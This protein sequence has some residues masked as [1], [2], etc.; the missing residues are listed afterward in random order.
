MNQ[1]IVVFKPVAAALAD[2]SARYK[3]VVFDVTTT[4]GMADAKASYKAI[5]THSITLE[6]ARVKEKADSL[7][8]GRFV[9][10][11]AKRIADA[12]DALR[13]PIKAQIEIETKRAEREREAAV[14]AEK[15]R[16]AAEEKAR[17]DAE[18][19]K[20]AADRA[21]IARQRAELEA[22]AKAE[23]DRLEEAR[24]QQEGIERAARAK[25]EEA[26]RASRAAIEA[27]EREARM[28]RE[29][30]DREAKAARDAEEARLKAERDRLDAEARAIAEAKRLAQEKVDAE[31]KAKREAEEAE[32]REK[33]RLANELLDGEEML[34]TF[35]R[36]YGKRPEFQHI[37]KLILELLG[38]IDTPKRKAA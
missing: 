37:G 3:G 17:K 11:E 2:L 25:I 26:E 27:Q 22:R 19:A 4:D 1:E 18:E 31:A 29:Q 14:Q 23:S 15:D 36:K 38:P 32:Q 20:L 10:S 16:L 24:I 9:D 13:L 35:Y 8:Y 30:A 34:R 5:N 12:L 6:Q 33:Q 28:A 7:A 21:E